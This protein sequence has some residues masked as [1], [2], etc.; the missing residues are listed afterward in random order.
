M[1]LR[2]TAPGQEEHRGAGNA[3]ESVKELTTGRSVP[4]PQKAHVRQ[5]KKGC[6]T[7]SGCDYCS[8]SF[9]PR[10]LP[11]ASMWLP[12]G[13]RSVPPA[14][15]K[16]GPPLAERAATLVLRSL[17]RSRIIARRE[18]PGR[19]AGQ[20]RISTLKGCNMAFLNRIWHLRL[21]RMR[22]RRGRRDVATGR[23]RA[24]VS[25]AVGRPVLRSPE[26]EAGRPTLC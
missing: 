17:R 9:F 3:S 24:T 6:C 13:E 7:P 18:S 4:S 10:A 23:R 5:P 19:N 15:P 21:T 1:I 12:V 22:R 20:E 8:N 16:A 14:V 11:W 25:V 2:F 26:G